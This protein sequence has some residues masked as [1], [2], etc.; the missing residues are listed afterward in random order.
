MSEPS[1]KVSSFFSLEFTPELAEIRIAFEDWAKEIDD[2]SRPLKDVARLFRA[3]ERRQFETEGSQT[4]ARWEKL[5]TKGAKGGYD[6]W[7]ARRFPGQPIL[8]RSGVLYRAMT[9]KGAPGSIEKVDR[10]NLFVGI[11]PRARVTS[12]G[13]GPTPLPVYARANDRGALV[14]PGR[15]NVLPSRPI[16]RFDGSFE[17]KNK[18]SFGYAVSQIMQAYIVK[19]RK[20]SLAER[21]VSKGE[22]TRQ[23]AESVAKGAESTYKRTVDAMIGRGLV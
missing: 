9:Q 3:H 15:K 23:Q 4:G 11:N 10:K 2:F 7:K 17:D 20:V 22:M 8:Q 1:G 18:K 21:A 5:S 12:K 6:A 13:G 14:G 19:S 16:V